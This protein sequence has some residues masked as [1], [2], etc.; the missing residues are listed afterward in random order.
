MSK[1]PSIFVSKLNTECTRTGGPCLGGGFFRAL[2]FEVSPN[3]GQSLDKHVAVTSAH[4]HATRKGHVGNGV[5][6]V[7]GAVPTELDPTHCFGL[8][9]ALDHSASAH[10]SAEA[11]TA[12]IREIIALA[13][14][15]TR[16]RTRTPLLCV[17]DVLQRDGH[18]NEVV[19]SC[20]HALV[21][22]SCECSE[23]FLQ[24]G[25]TRLALR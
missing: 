1:Q 14:S 7:G 4:A 5:V 21:A 22:L 25:E 2:L 3:F 11:H 10:E 16:T 23:P 8:G 9:G 20:Q 15:H 19:V 24:V 17:T 12:Q 18:G 6:A 13:F